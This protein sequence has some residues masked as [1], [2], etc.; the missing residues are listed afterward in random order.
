MCSPLSKNDDGLVEVNLFK[1][2]SLYRFA[3]L[4]DD[5]SHGTHINRPEAKRLMLYHQATTVE[6]ASPDPFWLVIDGEMLHTNRYR[7][8]NMRHAVTFVAPAV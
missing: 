1:R 6:M 2:M 7:V 3:S 5:Y 4:I 8:V